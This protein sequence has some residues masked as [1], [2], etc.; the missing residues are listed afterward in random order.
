MAKVPQPAPALAE[1]MAELQ[2][3][4]SAQTRKTFANHGASDNLFGVKVGDLKQVLKRVKGHQAL[5]VALFETGNHDAQYLAGLAA[6]GA[7]LSEETLDRWARGTPWYMISEYTVPWLVS[8]HPDGWQIALRWL[9]DPADHVQAAG[10]SALSCLVQLRADAELDLPH[11]R[12]LLQRVADRLT[13]SPNRCRYA[14]NGFVIAVGAG[15]AP[16]YDD[17]LAVA[18]QLGTVHVHMGTT[19][20]KVPGAPETLTKIAAMGRVG[21]KRATCKC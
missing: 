16:L 15:V 10:W 17:A 12:A 6:N 14:M 13:A 19:A 1:V 21:H 5:A 20:C 18:H 3:L 7:L 8:E 4:G 9:D 11:L 2:A